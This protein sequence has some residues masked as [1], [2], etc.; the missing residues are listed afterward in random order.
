MDISDDTVLVD[1][2]RWIEKAVIGLNLCPFARSVYVKNQVRIVVS[3]A[4]HLDAFLDDLDRELDLLQ[5]TP[6]EEVD[7]TLLVHPTLFPDFEVFNDFQ[8]VVDDVVAEH[9]LEG[10]IQVAHFHPQFQFE[11]ATPED[12]TNCTNRAPYPTLHL[13]REDSVERAV[14]SDAG[15]AEQIVERNLQTLRSLGAVGWQALFQKPDAGQSP[16]C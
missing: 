12:V 13:L 4:R 2:R 14:A 3:S 16:V 1:T 7:T 10:V 5:S 11:G 8:N 15:D 9:G 6:A